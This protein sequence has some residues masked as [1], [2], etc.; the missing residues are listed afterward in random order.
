MICILELLAALGII[1]AGGAVIIGVI[2][3]GEALKRLAAFLVIVLVAPAVIA[4]MVRHVVVPA[5]ISL[6]NAA[7]PVLTVIGAVAVALL[8]VWVVIALIE[9]RTGAHL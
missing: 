8:I 1:L 5:A 2:P 7:K 3:P 4:Y 9:H 6:W